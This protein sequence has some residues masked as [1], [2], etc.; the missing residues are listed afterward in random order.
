MCAKSIIEKIKEYR[1]FEQL[2]LLASRY[3]LQEEEINYI[4]ELV[5]RYDMDWSAFLGCTLLNRVNGV[6]YRNIK[7]IANI[8][9]YVKYFLQIAYYE[10][11]ERTRLHQGEINKISEVFEKENIRYAFLKGA[12]LNTIFYQIGDRISNDTDMMVDV[13]DIEKV[14]KILQNL[15]YIQG[16]VRE[17]KLYSATKKELLFARLN[18][19]EIVPFNKPVDERYLPFHEVDINFRLS[20]D[21]TQ[22]SASVML[23]NTIVLNNTEYNIRTLS[24]EYFLVFLCI[25]HYREATMIFKIVSGND[26]TLYKFMDIHFLISSKYGEIN[27][28]QLL[29]IC[30][31]LGRQKDVYYTL[32]YT[33]KLYPNTL[34]DAILDKFKPENVDFLDEYKG[35]DNSQEI[36]K[37]EMDFVHRVFSNERRVEAMKNI[38]TENERYKEIRQQLES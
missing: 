21:D 23:Q 32:Y 3:K 6:V 36:Y 17:G 2:V 24:L 28:E 10:Q 4:K 7:D 5:K 20:N 14:T 18:T 13:N 27:W 33:E 19:Y 16:E 29:E 25:H 12:V 37:W 35:R 31:A 30:I 26:L 11:Q 38:S 34:D 8:P 9:K 22:E 15:G 1:T